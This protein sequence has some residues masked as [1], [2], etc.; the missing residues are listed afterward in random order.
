LPGIS[1][2][3]DIAGDLTKKGS[4]ILQP[5][6]SIIH[7]DHYERKVLLNERFY[8]L[9][10]T[11]YEGYSITTFENDDFLIYLEGQIYGKEHSTIEKELMNVTEYVFQPHFK[12][13]EQITRWLLDTD[14]E[15]IIF[16]LHKQSNDIGIMNDALARLS[17]YYHKTNGILIGSREIRFV[18]S[19]MRDRKFDKMAIAQHLLFGY[20]FGKRTLLENVYRLQPATLIRVSNDGNK[21]KMYHLHR[22]NFEIKKYRDKKIE[23]NASELIS[24]FSEACKNRAKSNVENIVSLS[25]GLDSRSVAVCLQNNGI[26]FHAVTYLDFNRTVKAE[27]EIAERLSQILNL[28]FRILQLSNPKGKDLLRLL[29]MKNGLNC[30]AMGFLLLFL[31][32]I[33]K[34]YSSRGNRLL[35]GD[36]GDHLLRDKRPYRNLRDLDGLVKYI[37]S[38]NGIFSLEEVATLT[39][40]EKSSLIDEIRSHVLSYPEQ[41]WNQ[42]YVHFDIFDRGF[43]WSVEGEDRNRFFFWSVAPFYSPNFFN[44]AM[45]CPD[46]QKS[47]YTL[48]RNF[49]LELSPEASAINNANW[50]L[51]ITSLRYKIR[52]SLTDIIFRFFPLMLSKRQ[53]NNLIK[54]TGSY[55]QR[56]TFISCLENQINSCSAIHEYLSYPALK[57]VVRKRIKY[58]KRQIQVLFTVVS[59][60]EEI[61]CEGS[62]IEKYYESEFE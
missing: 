47:R 22:Y 61:E 36:G 28:D 17:F 58:S 25:G 23:D 51:P 20:S 40:I 4:A 10:C 32:G 42:K 59:S 60:I 41:D 29:R 15:F 43:K 48:Y 21:I 11:R 6:G 44:Y 38:E 30:L 45:N 27:V 39:Q 35:T 50:N 55:D 62:T 54:N 46:K 33:K 57:E 5:S 3:F 56:S 12:R 8:F 37:L 53:I 26:P 2:V 16:A 14:G 18:H 49:L 7:A 34:H 52:S 13:Q 24:L 19:L 9:G 1:F 31:E